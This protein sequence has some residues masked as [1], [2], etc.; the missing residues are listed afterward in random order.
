MDAHMRCSLFHL[1]DLGAS[2]SAALNN[3]PSFRGKWAY[4]ASR[5]LSREAVVADETFS[6]LN[7]LRWQ[8]LLPCA[9]LEATV[10]T[11]VFLASG[12]LPWVPGPECPEAGAQPTVGLLQCKGLHRNGMQSL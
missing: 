3:D 9:D 8:T 2:C 4:P 7:A 5:D 10:H 11:L 12:T 1:V 6:S